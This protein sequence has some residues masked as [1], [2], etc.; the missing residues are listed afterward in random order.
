MIRAMKR[1]NFMMTF[2]ATSLVPRLE[3][4]EDSV[5]HVATNTYPWGTFAS[6]DAGKFELHTDESLAAISS[7]GIN[8]YEPSVGSAQEFTDLKERLKKHGLEM[9]SLYVGS[10]MHERE[11]AAK[12]IDSMRFIAEHAAEIGCKIIVTNPS[13]L[14]AGAGKTD[15]QL[16]TQAGALDDLGVWL[17]SHGMMLAYHNHN[18]ELKNGA[19]EFH[20]MLS[21]TNPEHVHFC[22]DAHWVFRGC[23][24][25]QVA[26]FD[27]LELYGSRVV[28][29]H[30][31]QSAKGVW[32]EV[33]TGQGDIDYF[34]MADWLQKRELR[35][36]LVLEQCVEAGSPHTLNAVEA[37]KQSVKNVREVFSGF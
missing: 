15:E 13:P 32:T 31:R 28:E 5:L 29:L 17:A 1:R 10:Q 24:D 4:A 19:R 2:A 30:L 35:P 8:G 34:R 20:H 25:S 33:F 12:S 27:V 22:M 3:A 16:V 21:S 37:H 6:R 9:R 11:A 26:V 18:V 14:P 36:H 23:G 7:S